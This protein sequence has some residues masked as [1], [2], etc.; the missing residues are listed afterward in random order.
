V[1]LAVSIFTAR[2]WIS[3]MRGFAQDRQF[4]RLLKRILRSSETAL[5]KVVKQFYFFA[6]L[7]DLCGKQY[8]YLRISA[9]P[10]KCFLVLFNWGENLPAQ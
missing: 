2:A 5:Y 6:F 3:P 7:S 10:V 1:V 9:C 4:V 8:Q